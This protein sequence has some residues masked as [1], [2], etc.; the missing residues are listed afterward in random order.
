MRSFFTKYKGVHILFWVVS[1]II[2]TYATM[3]S[4]HVGVWESLRNNGFWLIGQGI[5]VYTILYWLMPRFFY[6]KRYWTFGLSSVALLIVISLLISWLMT[7]LIQGDHPHVK[8]GSVLY[9]SFF[10]AITNFYVCF[11]FIA[12]KAVKD[13]LE[14]DRH[15]R[16]AEKARAENE[17]RFL[18]SQMNPHFL[19]NAINSIYVLIRKDQEMAASTL[20]TF[21]DMLRYQLYECNTE[22]IPV[23]REVAYLNNYVQLEKIR[24][25]N[26][27]Q[28][29]Y[30]VGENVRHFAI[31]PL[32]VIPFVENAFKYVST[33]TQQTNHIRI[34]L[35]HQD[36][37]F[38]LTVE[39]S[40]EPV[41]NRPLANGAGGIGLENV[42]RRLE[43]IYK[44]HYHLEIIPGDTIYK[45]ILTIKNI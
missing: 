5:L 41:L 16:E 20:A 29:D 24:K 14:A 32:L 43:L 18:K 31:A 34:H 15:H 13:K 4:Y 28:L 11:F 23:D 35:D 21:A 3:N 17:L 44:G 6:S 42:K 2:W 38:L 9:F 1:L 10:I 40:V 22:T 39:N 27:L 25:G 45:I 12:A 26:A 19:F 37:T 33:Y 7:T 30:R 36:G 8:L